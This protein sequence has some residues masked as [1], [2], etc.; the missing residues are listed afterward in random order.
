MFLSSNSSPLLL[1]RLNIAQHALVHV[2]RDSPLAAERLIHVGND[3][4]DNN[5]CQRHQPGKN[6]PYHN[7]SF[8]N[9]KDK[10]QASGK[11]EKNKPLNRSHFLVKKSPSHGSSR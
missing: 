5:E 11:E 10:E 2:G 7:V 9:E 6:C 4:S 8:G 1:I 3:D